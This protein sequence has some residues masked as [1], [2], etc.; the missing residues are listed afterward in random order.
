[1]GETGSCGNL[2]L[3]VFYANLR[4]QNPL[5]TER[6]ENQRKSANICENVRSG[7]GFSLCCLPLAHPELG[8]QRGKSFK[9]V[10]FDGKRHDNKILK[11][12]I[13]L[14]RTF[15]VTAQAPIP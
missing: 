3:M 14:S 5:I 2:F 8:G 15:I 6:A 13:L 11:L 7:P 9:D 4:L 10:V 1:M 12:Q